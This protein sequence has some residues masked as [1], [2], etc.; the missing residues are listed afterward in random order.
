MVKLV[1]YLFSAEKLNILET[2]SCCNEVKI[3]P[4]NPF[5]FLEYK[6]REINGEY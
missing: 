1:G 5:R 6:L 2:Y 4:V 3:G